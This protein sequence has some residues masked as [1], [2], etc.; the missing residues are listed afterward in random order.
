MLPRGIDSMHALDQ[1]HVERVALARKVGRFLTRDEPDDQRA[2]VEDIAR[3]LL[4]DVSLLVRQT[5]AFELRLC[6]KLDKGL[7]DTIA[8]DI[9]EVA[10]PFLQ[11]S[12]SFT[13]SELAKLVPVVEEHARCAIARRAHVPDEVVTVLVE[14]AS[15]KT[16]TYLVRNPGAEMGETSCETLFRRFDNSARLMN[17]LAARVDLPLGIVETLVQKVSGEYQDRLVNHYK[18][19]LEQA[20]K[21]AGKTQTRSL[22][23]FLKTAE[24]SRVLVYIRDLKSCNRLKPDLILSLAN[25]SDLRFLSLALSELLGVSYQNVDSLLRNG[26]NIGLERL[27]LKARIPPALHSAFTTTVKKLR[28]AEGTPGP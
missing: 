21:L 7:R 22:G 23:E 19:P 26:G 3:V 28:N 18:V 13:A 10:D 17:S 8:R 6:D 1:T 11:A 4:Q 27:M 12:E 14:L 24:T 16:V 9:D 2:V 20:R 5:L 15:E 25:Q